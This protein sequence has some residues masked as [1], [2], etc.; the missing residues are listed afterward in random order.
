MTDIESK[1]S[2]V[3]CMKIMLFS[4]CAGTDAEWCVHGVDDYGMHVYTLRGMVWRILQVK[5][6]VARYAS[7]RNIIYKRLDCIG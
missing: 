7:R 5:F 6:V 3:M 4:M 2:A 1:Y